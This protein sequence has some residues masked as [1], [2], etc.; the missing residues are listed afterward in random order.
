MAD[1]EVGIRL[2]L[3][4]R[5]KVARGLSDTESAA[6]EVAD[7]TEKIGPAGEKA[8]RG[9]AKAT[10]ARFARGFRAILGG[11]KGVA[12]FLGRGLVS[13]AKTGAIGLSILTVGLAGVSAKAINLSSDARETSSAFDTVFGPAADRVGGRL[14]KL[15]ARFGLYNPESAGRRA[16][17]R[18]VRQGG[19]HPAEGA[20]SVLDQPGQGRPRPELLLQQR[21]GRD[22]RCAAVRAR[23]RGRAAPRI[24]HLHLRRLDEGRGRR[25][26][27][28]RHPDGAAEGDGAPA[29]HHEEPRRRPGRPGAD[30][31]GLR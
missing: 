16:P 18:G 9:L 5:Q 19:R 4:D 21:P 6:E 28:D 26:G 1:R 29:A 30:L 10:A 13:S 11:A 24:R 15:T 31:A 17:V 8:S 20:R 12:G 2:R 3:R 27:A 25:D 7:A 23:R 14:D 22:L